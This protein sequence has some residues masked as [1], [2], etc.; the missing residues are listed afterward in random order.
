MSQKFMKKTLVFIHGLEST[1]RGTKGQYFQKH[2]PEMTVEDFSGNFAARMGKLNYILEEKENLIIVGSS[3]GGTMAVQYTGENEEKV[4]KLILL[5]PALGIPELSLAPGKIFN[6]P[7]ILYHGTKDNVVDP[8]TVKHIAQ[9]LFV[10]LEHH[11]VDDDHFLH[12]TFPCLNW[13]KLLETQRFKN[14]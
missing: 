8:Y 2:F 1:A 7:V 10:H 14:S 6:I 11:L 12:K 9:K 13:F 3:Y 5:A 4:R